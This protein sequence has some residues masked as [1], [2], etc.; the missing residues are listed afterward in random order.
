M[1]G[2][3]QPHSVNLFTKISGIGAQIKHFQED[4]A[5]T[6]PTSDPDY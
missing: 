4:I 2:S 5:K 3:S 6:L 1:I